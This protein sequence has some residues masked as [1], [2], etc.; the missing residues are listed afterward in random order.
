[1]Q[2]TNPE[3]AQKL[4][5]SALERIVKEKLLPTPENYQLWY[6][7]YSEENPEITRAIDVLVA[8]GQALT[9]E[10][11]QEIHQRFLSDSSENERVRQAGDK[12]QTTIKTVSGMVSNVKEATSKYNTRLNDMTGEISKKGTLTREDIENIISDV[13]E[14]TQDMMRHNQTLEE[15]L[16]KSSRAMKELQRDLDLGAERGADGRPDEFVEPQGVRCR[17][18][19]YRA[20]FPEGRPNFL[21][22]DD[23]YRP[24]QELQRFIRPPGRRPGF[25]AGG[26]DAGGWC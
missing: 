13:M 20:R 8:T 4:S 12:I 15:E 11:C 14:G 1:V 17:N 25:E 7:Y 6:V 5:K 16:G 10:R 22:D 24:F 23:G 2:T 21:V 3:K 18:S 9:D 26:A 19:P